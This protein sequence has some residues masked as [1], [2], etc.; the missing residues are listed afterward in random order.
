MRGRSKARQLAVQYLYQYDLLKEKAAD[1]NVFLANESA[2]EDV[3][4]F[5]RQLVEGCRAHWDELNQAMVEASEHWEIRRMPVVDRNILRV[6]IYELKYCN[7]IPAKVAINEAIEMAKSFGGKDS[8]AFVNGLLDK[9][10][11]KVRGE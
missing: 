4:A 3:G 9:I 5:A 7:D 8:G 2:E 10:R 1:L 11:V 6:G